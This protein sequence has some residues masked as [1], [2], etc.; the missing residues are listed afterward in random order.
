MKSDSFLKRDSRS[1]QQKIDQFFFSPFDDRG[2]IGCWT[3]NPTPAM[4]ETGYCFTTS[5]VSHCLL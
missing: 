1:A 2:L 4:E 3:T 5:Y